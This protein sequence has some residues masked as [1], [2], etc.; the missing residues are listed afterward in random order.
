M[1][2]QKKP[3]KKKRNLFLFVT[4][5][6][7]KVRIGM[8]VA[9][10]AV[11]GTAILRTSSAQTNYTSQRFNILRVAHGETGHLDGSARVREYTG[12]SDN[13][14][15][16]ASF[17]SWV[18]KNSGYPLRDGDWRVP[19]V[20]RGPQSGNLRDLFISMGAYQ[21]Y[22]GAKAPVAP[23][24][25]DVIL[26]SR[27]HTGIVTK[28]NGAELYTI[29]GNSGAA[30]KPNRVTPVTYPS[31]SAAGVMGWGNVDAIIS[32]AAEPASPSKQPQP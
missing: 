17:V 24:P 20:Y 10:F 22:T 9:V 11:L 7:N 18:M 15:W 31:L 5:Q 8:V 28:M 30:G 2:K 16:C 13:P 23:Q 4:E 25:G 29:E 6:S 14:E 32:R 1:P 27:S 12:R 21:E 3:I 19:A 26:F